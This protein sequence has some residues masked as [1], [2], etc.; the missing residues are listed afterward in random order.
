MGRRKVIEIT[1]DRCS[2]KETQSESE[3][4]AED[5]N[6]FQGEFKEEQVAFSDLCRRCRNTLENL[7]RRIK[8]ESFED[9]ESKVA[10]LPV[11]THR[12]N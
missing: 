5:A 10:K 4:S 11:G 12:A 8:R 3:V 2:K 7:F 1:C 6:E 9:E